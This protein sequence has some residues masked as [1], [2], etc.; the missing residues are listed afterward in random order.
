MNNDQ[1]TMHNK[2]RENNR[3]FFVE[4]PME[5]SAKSPRYAPT[6]AACGYVL[7]TAVSKT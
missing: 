5:Y 6:H 2:R 1:G 4:I 3:A 7:L